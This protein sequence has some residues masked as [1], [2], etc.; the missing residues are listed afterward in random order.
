MALSIRYPG[1]KTKAVTMSFDDGYREDERLIEIFDRFGIRGTF[2]INSG[3]LH[4]DIRVDAEDVARIYKNHEISAHG[5][6]HANF[7]ELSE[8]GI[9]DEL[10]KDCRE[11]SCLS[12]RAIR[13]MS[14]PNGKT[15]EKAIPIAKSLGIAYSRTTVSTPDFSIPEDFLYWHPTCHHLKSEE[16]TERFLKSEAGGELL[17]IWGHSSEFER[18]QNW[19]LIEE[20]CKKLGENEDI[21]SATCIEFCDYVTASR[22]IVISPDKKT[23]RNP[24]EL[25][26]WFS[27]DGETLCVKAGETI[28]L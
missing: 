28:Y 4:R 18:D 17:C 25:D 7:D 3:L 10:D 16:A 21:W 23:F 9:F 27:L 6:T 1:G 13:G 11:L 14:Y 15:C 26:V 20:V 5:F 22:N 24:T 8:E 2:H 19:E 12:G